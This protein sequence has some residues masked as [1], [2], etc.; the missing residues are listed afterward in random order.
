MDKVEKSVKV[1]NQRCAVIL[2]DV[3]QGKMITLRT[4]EHALSMTRSNLE[5]L[6]DE[7]S[8]ETRFLMAFTELKPSTQL[9]L[10]T[11]ALR[12]MR[13]LMYDDLNE[14]IGK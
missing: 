1:R 2:E 11:V 3:A 12:L 14:R 7:F 5:A 13:Q 6:V 10:R 9:P 8:S 4:P